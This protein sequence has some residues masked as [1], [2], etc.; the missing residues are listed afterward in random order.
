MS[1]S[2]INSMFSSGPERHVC[3][4]PALPAEFVGTKSRENFTRLGL[5]LHF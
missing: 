1:N 2:G 5:E 3:L 4:I